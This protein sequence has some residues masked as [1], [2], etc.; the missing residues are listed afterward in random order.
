MDSSKND[1]AGDRKDGVVELGPNTNG[2]EKRV[3]MCRTDEQEE[4]ARECALEKSVWQ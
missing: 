1:E 3:L 4:M 2:G